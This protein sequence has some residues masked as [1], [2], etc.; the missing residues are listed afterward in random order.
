ML[1][2][3]K[4]DDTHEDKEI[5]ALNHPFD[6]DVHYRSLDNFFEK[7][8]LSTTTASKIKY[9]LII[10]SLAIANSSDATE[11]LFIS[12]TLSDP[13]FKSTMLKDGNGGIVAASVF[14]GMLV[15]GSFIGTFSDKYGR[16]PTLLIG[17][18]MNALGGG[19]SAISPNVF[20]L[21]LTR[22]VA[23]VGIGE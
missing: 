9:F 14:S 7:V 21:I 13:T 10:L 3:V 23:G 20:C 4:K 1:S 18:L 19:C 22:F 16:K 11:I 2:T 15:G 12:F 5:Q 8:Y 6:M 17:L